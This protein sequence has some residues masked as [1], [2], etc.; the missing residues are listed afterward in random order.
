MCKIRAGGFD[1]MIALYGKS[2][3]MFSAA[4]LLFLGSGCATRVHVRQTVG[5]VDARVSGAAK[6]NAEQQAA[7]GELGNSVSRADE[8]AMDAERKATAAGGAAQTAHSR[9]DQAHGR[10]DTA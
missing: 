5:P 9:A 6:R 8:R 4:M 7:N 2:T 10:A 1:R 3:A